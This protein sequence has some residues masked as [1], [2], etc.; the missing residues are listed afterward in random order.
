[1]RRMQIKMGKYAIKSTNTGN[2]QRQKHLLRDSCID[3]SNDSGLGTDFNSSLPESS[4]SSCLEESDVD[5][6]S[7][8]VDSGI[9]CRNR[10]LKAKSRHLLL[11]NANT[12]NQ[13][14]YSPYSMMHIDTSLSMS[15]NN[16]MHIH[17]TN[18]DAHNHLHGHNEPP[19]KRR[20]LLP[21][22]VSH[23]EKPRRSTVH[24][25]PSTSSDTSGVLTEAPLC[26]N[27]SARGTYDEPVLL[28]LPRDSVMLKGSPEY[29]S[30]N[31]EHIAALLS[32]NSHT[33]SRKRSTKKPSLHQPFPP[34]SKDGKVEL[35]ILIQPEEQHRARYM[36]EGSRGSIKDEKGTGFPTIKL[37]GYNQPAVLQIFIG[38]DQGK[39]QPHLFYQACKV[40]GKNCTPCVERV[41]DGTCVIEIQLDPTNEMTVSCDCIGILKERNVD[42]EQRLP[43]FGMSRCKKRSTKCRMV[44]RVNMP[45]ANGNYET[46]QITSSPILCTQSPGLPEICKKSLTECPA[47]GGVDLFIIGKNFQ[48]DARITFTQFAKEQGHSLS[49]G[50]IV[51][52]ESVE[53]EKE[54]MHQSHLV[55][56]VPPYCDQ[57]IE[58]PVKLVLSVSSGGKSSE[59][60]IFTYNPNKKVHKENYEN[61]SYD[62]QSRI[63]SVPVE[64]K[65]EWNGD[66]SPENASNRLP[67]IMGDVSSLIQPVSG[68]SIEN[69]NDHST[70]ASLIGLNMPELQRIVDA[71]T[72]NSLMNQCSTLLN[73]IPLQSVE[74][75]PQSFTLVS[76]NE[77]PKV[78]TSAV[79][80]LVMNQCSSLLN[81]MPMPPVEERSSSFSL[82][83]HK[84]QSK[85]SEDVHHDDLICGINQ[86][87]SAYVNDQQQTLHNNETARMM[88]ELQCSSTS[89]LNTLGQQPTFVQENCFSSNCNA[90][91]SEIMTMNGSYCTT[92][93]SEGLFVSSPSSA[94]TP[95]CSATL[96]LN[97]DSNGL[98]NG[99][100]SDMN[101]K[102]LNNYLMTTEAGQTVTNSVADISLSN[103][104]VVEYGPI[105]NPTLML[106]NNKLSS[107][108]GSCPNIAMAVA[109]AAATESQMLA[110]SVPPQEA[111]MVEE[112]NSHPVLIK[113]EKIDVMS[114]DSSS[115]SVDDTSMPFTLTTMS[116]NDLLKM[117][118][119]NDFQRNFSI[120]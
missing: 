118:N 6:S 38:C 20:K 87:A 70:P 10:R 25:F 55:C 85:V 94:T 68:N 105:P 58:N 41:V 32:P 114:T 99:G 46:L 115:D 104:N 75:Q 71:T 40:T 60:H 44:F 61:L 51:W 76:H 88:V 11:A 12:C 3:E 112:Q 1:M 19:T 37:T 86:L 97:N 119:T 82:V 15:L 26:V 80:S 62:I 33:L 108:M 106:P 53:P 30:R 31:G 7:D 83:S 64:I 21:A 57:E 16:K 54:F 5:S 35:R 109:T 48:K 13:T 67:E 63:H 14:V 42:V 78:D 28:D 52:E 9:S 65:Q 102:S 39:V 24:H 117:I 89:N 110:A 27:S 43:Y 22:I 56:C 23:D 107:I 59:P 120:C 2:N 84:E 93:S 8:S 103:M 98:Y 96:D 47:K 36:T 79:N 49:R 72:V 91:K 17:K 92:N 113:S 95:M 69:S 45:L 90:I 66:T 100:S 29:L 81:D 111:R 50:N 77:Q 116:D 18:S 74:E 34:V 4:S 73:N 101:S